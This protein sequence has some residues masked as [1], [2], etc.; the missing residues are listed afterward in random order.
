MCVAA[1]RAFSSLMPSRYSTHLPRRRQPTAQSELIIP[2]HP[3]PSYPVF[4]QTPTLRHPSSRIPSHP[5]LSTP[6]PPR[7]ITF[8]SPSQSPSLI[9]RK[10]STCMELR[11]P[12]AHPSA[13]QSQRRGELHVVSQTHEPSLQSPHATAQQWLQCGRPA[14]P[15]LATPLF[16]M[17]VGVS[18][19]NCA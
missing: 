19:C 5:I 15:V 10:N 8:P 1:T 3:M 17:V 14:T 12:A 7:P 9:P 2:S 13:S 11:G 18:W 16:V 6:L 4:S